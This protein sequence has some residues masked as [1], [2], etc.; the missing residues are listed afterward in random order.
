LHV[1]IAGGLAVARVPAHKA[2]AGVCMFAGAFGAMVR[3]FGA[4][5]V[6]TDAALSEAIRHASPVLEKAATV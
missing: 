3:V 2:I 1:E 5:D 4:I 6:L